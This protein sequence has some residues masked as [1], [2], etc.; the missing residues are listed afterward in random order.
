[1]TTSFSPSKQNILSTLEADALTPN[2]AENPV[3]YSFLKARLL[4]IRTDY[5]PEV[6]E[7]LTKA[8]KLKPADTAL[9]NEL[10]ELFNFSLCFV[11]IFPSTFLNAYDHFALLPRRMLPQGGRL[12]D[13]PHLL[14]D[15]AEELSHR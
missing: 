11:Y 5:D 12:Q 4:N 15:G 7:L 14:R 8:V 2:R 3:T 9:W 1:M 10:G 6:K 13:G